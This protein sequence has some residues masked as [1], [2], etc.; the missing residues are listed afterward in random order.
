MSDLNIEEQTKDSVSDIGKYE[1]LPAGEW[2]VGTILPLYVP[3]TIQL[4]KGWCICAGQTIL[5]PESPFMNLP[6]PNLIDGRFPMGTIFTDSYGKYGGTNNIATS[7][8]HD[9]LYTIRKA[10]TRERTPDGFQGEG[11]ECKTVT[12]HTTGNGAHDHGGENR[13][14]WF[15]LLYMIKYK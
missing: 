5:D 9:H 15:G 10:G 13:P 12:L 14:Q 8:N 4:P 7:G 11:P 1:T 2:P 3:K 6:V